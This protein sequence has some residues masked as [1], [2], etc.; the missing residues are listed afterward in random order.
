[1]AHERVHGG[2]RGVAWACRVAA[3]ASRTEIKRVWD[4]RAELRW[5]A[6]VAALPPRLAHPAPACAPPACSFLPH[7][8]RVTNIMNDYPWFKYALIAALG[9]VVVTSKEG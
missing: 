3:A 2:C 7:I 1:M 6:S 5:K 4:V 9:V 8:G